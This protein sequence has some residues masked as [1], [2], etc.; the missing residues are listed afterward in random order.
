M[1][2]ALCWCWMCVFQLAFGS[3]CTYCRQ[4]LKE[5]KF[6]ETKFQEKKSFLRTNT[7]ARRKE[8]SFFLQFFF[9]LSFFFWKRNFR[10]DI[11]MTNNDVIKNS[12]FSVFSCFCAAGEED[13][14]LMT[15]S[16]RVMTSSSFS[17]RH[18]E[19]EKATDPLSLFCFSFRFW[20]DRFCS[21][22]NGNANRFVFARTRS[23]GK[24]GVLYRKL[25]KKKGIF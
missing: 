1:G 21:L 8:L 6:Q 23:K 14:S 4:R 2:M 3:H 10:D 20:N 11:K 17:S 5:K 19:S 24:K 16:L 7:F 9:S 12:S 18:R 15:S 13:M 25:P 22:W